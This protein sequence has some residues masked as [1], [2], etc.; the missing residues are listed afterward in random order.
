MMNQKHS[1]EI[2]HKSPQQTNDSDC[3]YQEDFVLQL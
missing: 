1:E 3:N 2:N